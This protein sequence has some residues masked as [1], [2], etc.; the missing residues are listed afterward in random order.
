MCLTQRK[1]VKPLEN[2]RQIAQDAFKIFTRNKTGQL[3]SCFF[4]TFKSGLFYPP[5]VKIRVDNEDSNF[6]AFESFKN[7][8]DVA[9]AGK[10]RFNMV[11]GDLIVLPV[12][13]YEVVAIGKYHVPSDDLQVLDGYYTA[14]ESKEI[15]VHDT[16]KDRNLFYDETLAQ[17]L[18]TAQ[19][20]MS[21]VEKEAF[22]VR[23]PHLAKFLK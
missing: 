22:A 5:N 17:W 4:P 1:E 16:D 11:G 13:M 18:R 7:A 10:K 23:I 15:V 2:G 8:V 20:G 21:A 6:F 19:Y 14:F 9:R 12:T 3:Q